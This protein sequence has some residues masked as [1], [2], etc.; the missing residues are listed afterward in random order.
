MNR[1][2]KP[3]ESHSR[4][5][6]SY[7]I[8]YIGVV[9]IALSLLS[10]FAAWQVANRMRKEEIRMTGSKL[11]TIAEDFEN[12]MESM[13]DTALKL[14]SI[15]EAEQVYLLQ[16][17]Y[18]EIELLER[19]R[20]YGTSSDISNYFFL[21]YKGDDTIFTS[22]GTTLPLKV[23]LEEQQEDDEKIS[24]LIE[25]LCTEKKEPLIIYKEGTLPVLFFYPLKKYASSSIGRE[26]VLCFEVEESDMLRSMER[27]V[28]RLDGRIS[29]SY[30][31][32][33][34]YGEEMAG[35]ED[36]LER[37]S[38]SG[39]IRVT[40]LADKRIY[41]SV[42]DVF[43]PGEW[44]V[45]GCAAMILL[46]VA[47]TAA[48][49]SYQPIRKI[50]EK[51]KEA[52]GDQMAYDL[53]SIDFLIETLLR[54]EES[55]SELLQKQYMALREQTVRLISQGGYSEGLKERLPVLNLHLDAPV[56]GRIVCTF[57]NL[58][59]EEKVLDRLKQ[60]VE[61]LSDESLWLYP[62]WNVKG[63]L[64]IL[65]AM[66]EEYQ[67]EEAEEALKAL[68]EAWGYEAD[69]IRLE[70]CHD[71]TMLGAHREK[72]ADGTGRTGEVHAAETEHSDVDNSEVGDQKK[73]AAGRKQ[74]ITASM[75]VE[76]IEKNCTKYDLSLDLVAQE[77]HITSAYLC[78]ILKQETGV[79]YKEYLTELRIN[80]AKKMLK[81][82]DASVADVC[83]RVGYTNVS[84]FIKVF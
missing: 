16:S 41:F 68:F 74:K 84:Y 62:Y 69:V 66:S 18:H 55:N 17:K 58:T 14:A 19:L 29:V 61:A 26:S 13:R 38:D 24:E 22:V 60:D 12:Q 2:K 6:R 3:H 73:S 77:F 8:S 83:Q 57:E 71:L 72:A 44:M 76:Y 33:T 37:I 34:I 59:E 48:Y 46:F 7:I 30:K 1:E 32:I 52:A 65:A 82:K 27:I 15:K 56:Y 20:K 47:F 67:V 31:G 80:E 5:F 21:K 81:D 10:I 35:K 23:H 11:Y 51:Y 45:L 78:R 49:T 36:C 25:S 43:L 9:L 40:F 53:D 50:S 75:A 79:S 70:I 42:A 63:V 39:D 64:N 4:V 54:R 28:G